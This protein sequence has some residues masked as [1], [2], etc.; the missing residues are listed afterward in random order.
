MLKAPFFVTRLETFDPR[1]QIIYFKLPLNAKQLIYKNYTQHIMIVNNKLDKSFGPVGSSSGIFIFVVG[2]TM[3][4]YSFSAIFIVLLGAFVGFSYT[5][6][7]IDFNLKRIRFSNI[8]F[9]IIR[10]GK[11]INIEPEMLLGLK[12]S[13]K[14]WRSY[15]K[16][17]RSFDSTQIDFRVILYDSRKKLIMPLKKVQSVVLAKEELELMVSA[18]DLKPI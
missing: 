1:Q 7:Q 11:W 12:K 17:N 15:S 2:L 18:L 5:S 8:L 6:T 14:T 3:T 4:Y 13:N 9:G 10:T 16:G